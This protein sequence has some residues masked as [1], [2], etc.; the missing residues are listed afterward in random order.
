MMDAKWHD[1]RLL[2]AQDVKIHLGG[3]VGP[4]GRQNRNALRITRGNQFAVS[5]SSSWPSI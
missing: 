1:G 2:T 3:I 4:L 5:I